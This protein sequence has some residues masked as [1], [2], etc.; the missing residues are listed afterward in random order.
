MF[1]ECIIFENLFT[2][3]EWAICDYS[4]SIKYVCGLW[5]VVVGV[6]YDMGN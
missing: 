6:E 1:N 3:I 5:N 2:I 4:S